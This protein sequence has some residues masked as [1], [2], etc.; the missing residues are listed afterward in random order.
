MAIDHTEDN[1][2]LVTAL[3]GKRISLDSPGNFYG[4][5][6]GTVVRLGG[7]KKFFFFDVE[8]GDRVVRAG[9]PIPHHRPL[10]IEIL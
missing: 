6:I 3:I 2:A 5:E 1:L 9:R 4:P 8:D 7:S 10:Q